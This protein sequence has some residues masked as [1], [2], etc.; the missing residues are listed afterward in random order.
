[1]TNEAE[2]PDVWIDEPLRLADLVRVF[3]WSEPGNHKSVHYVP[4]ARLDALRAKL[5]ALAQ[6]DSEGKE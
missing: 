6:I 1:M 5:D 4:A 3:A 2:L